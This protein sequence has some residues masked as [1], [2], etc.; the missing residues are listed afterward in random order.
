MNKL[1]MEKTLRVL[2]IVTAALTVWNWCL[3]DQP[4]MVIWGIVDACFIG[5]PII[6]LVAAKSSG[7]VSM[8]GW[9]MT[10]LALI[11]IATIYQLLTGN[12]G[13][14]ATEMG[15]IIWDM[16]DSAVVILYPFLAGLGLD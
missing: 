3:A 13:T 1:T 16:V 8:K 7:S 2:L 11:G 5:L 9:A 15:G 14:P 10:V 4:S 12:F 6:Y